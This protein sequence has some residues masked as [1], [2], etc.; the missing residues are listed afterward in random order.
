MAEAKCGKCGKAISGLEPECPHC[1]AEKRYTK[2]ESDLLGAA[3][4]GDLPAVEELLRAGVR[5]NTDALFMAVV[6]GHDT[7]VRKMLE[8][9]GDYDAKDKHGQT[10]LILA[11]AEGHAGVVRA[12]L[13]AGANKDA[14]NATGK[15]ALMLATKSDVIM[16]LQGT[17]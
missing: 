16:A 5:P 4:E 15:T 17:P 14:K 10:L 8:H 9:G 11:A 12:L 1:R 3:S 7:I 13:A 6:K 2:K